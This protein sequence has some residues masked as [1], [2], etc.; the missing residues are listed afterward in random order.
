MLSS[1]LLVIYIYMEEV[2]LSRFCLQL[3]G[4]D[5]SRKIL[6]MIV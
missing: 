5:D 2:S 4:F 1:A 3:Q 6:R